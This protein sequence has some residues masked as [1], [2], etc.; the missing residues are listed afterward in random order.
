MT[1]GKKLIAENRKARFNYFIEDSFECG[2]ALEGSEVKS[3]K[4]GNLSFP[5]SFADIENGQVWLRNVHI[6][7]WKFAGNFAPAIDRKIRLLLHRDQIKRLERKIN[8]KGYTLVPLDFYLKNGFVKL[9]LGLCRGKKQFDKR[10][11]VKARDLERETAR[12]FK[13]GLLE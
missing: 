12:E 3:I 10:E 5:D 8:E 9:T 11:T 6:T 1:G 13:K 7:P 2:L 4:A